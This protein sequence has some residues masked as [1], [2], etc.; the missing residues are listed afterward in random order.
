MQEKTVK[1][2]KYKITIEVV[3]GPGGPGKIQSALDSS[4]VNMNTS[5]SFV[6]DRYSSLE[7]LQNLS[8]AIHALERHEMVKHMNRVI[9]QEVDTHVK[10]IREK[11]SERL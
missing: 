1:P 11:N 2:Y 3:D 5:A 6:S 9:C 4:Y 10:Q 8:E 7:Y